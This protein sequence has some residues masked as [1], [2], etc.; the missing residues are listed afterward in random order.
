MWFLL[1][2]GVFFVV[3]AFLLGWALG[4]SALDDLPDDMWR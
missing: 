3:V 1:F 4:M 2:L